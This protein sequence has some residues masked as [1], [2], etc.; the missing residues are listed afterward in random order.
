MPPLRLF[1]NDPNK[2]RYEALG[3][4]LLYLFY[5][6]IMYFNKTL[7]D[8]IVPKCRICCKS[9]K[10]HRENNTVLYDKLKDANTHNGD[11]QMNNLESPSKHNDKD[12]TENQV[13]VL[14]HHERKPGDFCLIKKE[15]QVTALSHQ[16]RKPGD[17]FVS[18][19]KKTK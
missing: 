8:C 17:C 14:S 11:L 15:N 5:I 3:L 2:S 12:Q 9:Y 1:L 16:E 18:S 19:R 7:E 10:H 4:V 6:I 13:T